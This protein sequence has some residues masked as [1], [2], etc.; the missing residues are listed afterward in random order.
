M[1]INWLITTEE[2]QVIPIPGIRNMRQMNDNMGSL[3]WS[4]TKEERSI[5]DKAEKN[6]I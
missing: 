6:T 3:G 1:V 5:I 2:V 4:L